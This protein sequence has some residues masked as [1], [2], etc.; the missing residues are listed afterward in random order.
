M[1]HLNAVADV[2]T[3]GVG[4]M[5]N[6]RLTIETD[7]LS[8]I[9]MDAGF[10]AK[11]IEGD[12]TAYA[13]M[14]VAASEDWPSRADIFG[15]MEVILN[16]LRAKPVP[17]GFD[18]WLIVRRADKRIVGDCG[19]KGSPGPDGAI[20]MGCG[21]LAAERRNGYA[22]E[23]S[24]ALLAWGLAQPGVS[25]VTADCLTENEASHRTLI[26]LGMA[27]TRRESGMIYFRKGK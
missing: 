27:E 21:I 26:K 16:D 12:P 7:R 22:F 10:M 13:D 5:A 11:L 23:A 3:E 18:A 15:G 17:D 14:G 9:T 2:K 24:E 19:F 4:G 25:A 6:Q 1:E 20:D 8:L